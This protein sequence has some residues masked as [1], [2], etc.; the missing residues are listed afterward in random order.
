MKIVIFLTLG[1][2]APLCNSLRR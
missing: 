2:L 1:C